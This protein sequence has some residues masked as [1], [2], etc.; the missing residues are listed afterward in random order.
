MC[1]RNHPKELLVSVVSSFDIE[2]TF[3]FGF[4]SKTFI[5]CHC[6][7][8]ETDFSLRGEILRFYWRLNESVW[9]SAERLALK[10]SS[11]ISSH[12][13][14]IFLLD[15][16]LLLFFLSWGILW[17][18][19]EGSWFDGCVS[20]SSYE[21]KVWEMGLGSVVGRERRWRRG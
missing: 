11:L 9:E 2:T 4:H 21:G 3:N 7:L 10:D 18:G 16:A 8:R 12:C 14:D 19:L 15:A 1:Q 6:F 17:Q 20:E 5:I 13:G